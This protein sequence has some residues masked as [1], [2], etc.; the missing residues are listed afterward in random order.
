MKK[1]LATWQE[2]RVNIL[3]IMHVAAEG[4][5][6]AVQVIAWRFVD[7]DVIRI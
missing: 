3:E 5:S 4:G 6:R 1:R 7:E 2:E